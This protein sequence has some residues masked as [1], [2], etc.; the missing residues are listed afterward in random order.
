[1]KKPVRY[2]LYVLIFVIVS[3]TAG[4]ITFS[5]FSAG[6]TVMVP[7][8]TSLNL[9]DAEG[10]LGSIGLSLDVQSEDYD[11][12]MP[13]GHVLSQNIE[14]G[15]LVRGHAEVSVV[16]S[17]GP[18]VRLIPSA[19]G[20]S[21]EDAKKLFLEKGI[22]VAQIIKVHSETEENGNIIAQR[23][24]PEKWTGEEIKLVVS[25]G[26]YDV[27]YY[28]PSFQGMLKDDALLLAAELGINVELREKAGA[29]A[30]LEIVNEQKP[31]PGAEI[32]T[33]DTVYLKTGGSD[34]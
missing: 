14:P 3:F 29:E 13:A 30:G 28:C 12:N 10:D 18:E 17:K 7:D 34:G 4:Y 9:K 8:L 33:G 23:P 5:L 1:M 25:A 27:I 20:E 24:A 21:L 16:V 31:P 19:L 26:P 11:P 2:S 15:S 22:A 6:L 32:K